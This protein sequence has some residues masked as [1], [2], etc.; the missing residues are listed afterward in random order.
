MPFWFWAIKMSDGFTEY[1][2]HCGNVFYAITC[3]TKW[4]TS[5]RRS[6][7]SAW[8]FSRMTPSPVTNELVHLWNVSR[9]VFEHSLS[10][11]SLWVDEIKHETYSLCTVFA[12][13][14]MS[15]WTSRWSHSVLFATAPQPHLP[16]LL[17]PLP[18]FPQ[19][20]SSPLFLPIYVRFSLF[21]YHNLLPALCNILVCCTVEP[22]PPR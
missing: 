20:H 22:R 21:S 8:A 2:G 16:R 11:P 6:L 5:P 7:V 13:E 3:F 14:Q 19:A 9:L 1:S 12:I 10:F 18:V 17:C 4:W 15:K